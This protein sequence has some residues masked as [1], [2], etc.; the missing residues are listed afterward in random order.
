MA[1]TNINNAQGNYWVLPTVAHANVNLALWAIVSGIVESAGAGTFNVVEAYSG[2]SADKRRVPTALFENTLQ[3]A[4]FLVGG[5]FGWQTGT[6]ANGDWIVLESTSGIIKFHLYLEVDSAT[7]INWALLPLGDFTP[8][9]TDVTPP[10]GQGFSA[11]SFGTAAGTSP[12]LVAQTVP[13]GSVNYSVITTPELLILVT[14]NGTPADRTFMYAGVVDSHADDTRPYVLKRDATYFGEASTVPFARLSFVDST[15]N[16]Q[17]GYIMHPHNSALNPFASTYDGLN[18]KYMLQRAQIFWNTV[19][20]RHTV[21]LHHAYYG[22][23]DL[24][25]SGTLDTN[26]YAYWCS[27]NANIKMAFDWDGITTV[28]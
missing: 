18:G 20:H 14:D 27:A 23:V 21:F 2:A 22:N 19:A 7:V 4:A 10:D 1:W 6:L 13:A 16:L 11:T 9:G 15:T 28:P 26:A 17:T 12:T 8:G 3:N 24:S 25:S 5:D